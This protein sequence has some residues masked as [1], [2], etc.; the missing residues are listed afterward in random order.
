MWSLLWAAK[1]IARWEGFSSRPYRD[2]AG[3]PTIGYGHT[4]GVHMGMAPI[5]VARGLRLL[6]TDCQVAAKGVARLVEVPLT[7][8]QRMALISFTFN[9]GIGALAESKLLK[10]LNRGDYERAANQFLRWNKAGGVELLGLTRRRRAERK[11]FLSTRK[12][13]KG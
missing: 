5:S 12:R 7:V 8:R 3:V 10:M 13:R 2:A 4:K 11:M 6:A 9:C 1:W